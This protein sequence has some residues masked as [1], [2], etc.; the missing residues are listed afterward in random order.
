[1]PDEACTGPVP[2]RTKLGT[3]LCWYPRYPTGIRRHATARVHASWCQSLQVSTDPVVRW[4]RWIYTHA[5]PGPPGRLQVLGLVPC[6]QTPPGLSTQ[7]KYLPEVKYRHPCPKGTETEETLFGVHTT[8]FWDGWPQRCVAVYYYNTVPDGFIFWA[9][10]FSLFP[11]IKKS[12]SGYLAIRIR[13]AISRLLLTLRLS[14]SSPFKAFV[15]RHCRRLGLQQ[16][17][18]L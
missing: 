11:L 5:P 18:L 16:L 13:N 6:M 12:R 17:L 7:Y 9:R 3:L 1:M 4:L 2:A 15:Y 14:Q 8:A 10:F